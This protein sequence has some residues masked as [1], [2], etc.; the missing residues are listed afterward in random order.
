MTCT[1]G[2]AAA[3]A[4]LLMAVATVPAMGARNDTAVSRDPWPRETQV[5]S[6]P[7]N[8]LVWPFYTFSPDDRWVVYDTGQEVDHR[9]NT[10][11]ISSF[12]NGRSHQ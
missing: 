7:R 1:N 5:T 10:S 3:I 8:H 12:V 4:A 6:D 11:V 9:S 2:G